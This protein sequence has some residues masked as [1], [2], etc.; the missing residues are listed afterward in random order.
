M[1]DLRRYFQLGTLRA[2]EIRIFVENWKS[3]LSRGY[4]ASYSAVL[5]SHHPMSWGRQYCARFLSLP[6]T[7]QGT[8]GRGAEQVQ[9]IPTPLQVTTAID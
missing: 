4:F 5:F 9:K 1:F 3:P 6:R 7:C 8:K 2:L